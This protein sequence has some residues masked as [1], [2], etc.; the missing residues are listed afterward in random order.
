MTQIY[1]DSVLFSFISMKFVK[2]IVYISY[3]GESVQGEPGANG[4]PGKNGEP[5]RQGLKGLKGE[6]GIAKYR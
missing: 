6:P 2:K 4:V 5:G 3:T 1:N